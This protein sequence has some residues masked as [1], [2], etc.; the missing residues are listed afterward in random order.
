M[1][2]FVFD[3]LDVSSF[4]KTI[5]SELKHKRKQFKMSLEEASNDICSISY[6]CKIERNS[7]LP[8]DDILRK[9]SNRLGFSEN[10][11]DSL[12]NLNTLLDDVIESIYKEDYLNLTNIQINVTN[13]NNYKAKLIIIADKLFNKKNDNTSILIT[14]IYNLIKSLSDEDK[15]LIMYFKSI[16]YFNKQNHFESIKI[17]IKLNKE[18]VINSTLVLLIEDLILKNLFYLNSQNYIYHSNA[19]LNK[20]IVKLEYKKIEN[21][22]FYQSL[23]YIKNDRINEFINK[24]NSLK[25]SKYK[26][27]L[28]YI[29]KL[30]FNNYDVIK[31]EEEDIYFYKLIYY[32]K[33]DKDYYDS[34]I[35]N[36]TKISFNL[37]QTLYLKFLTLEYNKSTMDK[38]ILLL[39]TYYEEAINLSDMYL[40]NIISK[41][42]CKSLVD[43][44]H[45]KKAYYI[46]EKVNDLIEDVRIIDSSLL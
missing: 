15:W 13:F 29:N 7:I 9:I 24:Y 45:Y 10:E 31:K 4:Y 11:I 20:Y 42:L 6:L 46:R 36:S 17:L 33:F 3:E 19:L 5:G 30:I 22:Y 38:N 43:N 41:K 34:L 14:D 26:C 25:A 12:F 1:N 35:L 27:S 32:L 8:N 39:E 28:D 21:I 37:K 40:V 2:S 16:D 23:F 44:A 18:K